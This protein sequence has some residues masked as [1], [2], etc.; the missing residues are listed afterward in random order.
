M[1]G[2]TCESYYDKTKNYISFI[3][4]FKAANK[5]QKTVLCAITRCLMGSDVT[6]VFIFLSKI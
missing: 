1:L 5:N 3:A 4:F 6:V 2:I